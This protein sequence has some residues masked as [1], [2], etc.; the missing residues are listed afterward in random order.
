MWRHR[1]GIDVVAARP[2]P[3]PIALELQGRHREAAAAWDALGSPYEAAV[4]LSLADDSA[5]VAEAHGRLLRMGARPAAAAAARRLR[6]RGVRGIPRGPH[7]STL[8]NPANLTKRE[9]DVL[10][11]VSDGLSNAEIAE[12]LFLSRRTVDAHVS[13]ILRKLGVST[14]AR[15]VAAAAATGIAS[16]EG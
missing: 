12:R 13:A 15:A 8:E 14:R 9:L 10:A 3:D 16:P 2:L 6:E 11:L 5:L 4:A 7:R 1:A